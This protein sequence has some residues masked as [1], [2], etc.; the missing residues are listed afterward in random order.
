MALKFAMKAVVMPVLGADPVNH[1][2]EFVAG[3]R[4]ALPGMLYAV[5][6]GAGFGEETFYRGY[7]FERLGKRLGSTRS[8]KIVTLAVTSLLFAAAH[9]HDQG[10]AGAVQATITGLVFGTMLL[11][12]GTIVLPM[13]THVAFDLTA[14]WM[15]YSSLEAPIGHLIFR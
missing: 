8:A 11:R 2:Y 1:A 13:V 5:I 10:W 3:N 12:S 7:L 9:L 14:V 6:V 15:I 4:A